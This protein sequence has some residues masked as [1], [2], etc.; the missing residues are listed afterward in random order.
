MKQ[1]GFTI[2]I[3]EEQPEL[4]VYKALTDWSNLIKNSAFQNFPALPYCVENTKS[5][6]KEEIETIKFPLINKIVAQTLALDLVSVQ[7]LSIPTGLIMYMDNIEKENVYTRKVLV[8]K[9]KS[10]RFL[11]DYFVP[12]RTK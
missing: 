11:Q 10:Y 3:T 9:Y 2:S 7:P 12:L 8:E 1:S 6:K 4:S 5:K